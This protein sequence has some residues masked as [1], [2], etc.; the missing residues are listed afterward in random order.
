MERG[1]FSW[2][3]GGC[4]PRAAR[5][6]PRGRSTPR[7]MLRVLTGMGY[8]NGSAA[9]TGS[10]TTDRRRQAKSRPIRQAKSGPRPRSSGRAAALRHLIAR[11]APGVSS[12]PST[13]I[14][15]KR[16]RRGGAAGE[17][18]P[19]GLRDLAELAARPP[20]RTGARRPRS[21]PRSSRAAP[22]APAG[23]PARRARRLV[24]R[25]ARAALSSSARGRGRVEVIGAVEELD[26]VLARSFRPGIAA[27]ELVLAGPAAKRRREAARRAER[28]A[29]CVSIAAT[30]SASALP[31]M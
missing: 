16:R 29:A 23:P 19:Q 27:D 3:R 31:R 4:R 28:S 25:G 5:V 6:D 10:V 18:R 21:R 13:A 1:P 12:R 11:A 22:R 24:G 20:R 7:V 9:A 14:T 15:S 17:R 2:Q 8:P 26:S 30:R